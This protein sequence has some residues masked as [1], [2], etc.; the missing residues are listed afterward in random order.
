MNC[1]NA[2]LN[3]WKVAYENTPDIRECFFFFFFLSKNKDGKDF[4]ICYSLE[5]SVIRKCDNSH[6]N[7][8]ELEIIRVMFW[9]LNFF[10]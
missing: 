5:K 9:T 2:Q 4:G 6:V 3:L 7:N 8:L 1:I 10:V